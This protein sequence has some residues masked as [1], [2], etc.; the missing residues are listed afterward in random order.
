MDTQ[1]KCI[2]LIIGL[3][4]EAVAI[5]VMAGSIASGG[6]KAETMYLTGIGLLVMGG[7]LLV[8]VP[9]FQRINDL[10]KRMIDHKS[11][12][13]QALTEAMFLAREPTP[14]NGVR[15]MYR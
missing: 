8:A 5:G 1:V 2:I 11:H 3:G 6:L 15:Q 14:P 9:L 12:D 13:R 10:E 7:I 4:F